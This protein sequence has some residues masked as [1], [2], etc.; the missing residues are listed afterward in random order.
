MGSGA[1]EG[2]SIGPASKAICPKDIEEESLKQHE[3][4]EGEMLLS[5]IGSGVSLIFK[6]S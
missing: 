3:G 5:K 1:G 2:S 6:M 4:L